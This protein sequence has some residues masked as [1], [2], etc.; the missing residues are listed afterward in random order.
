MD[1]SLSGSHDE[2]PFLAY[3]EC[4]LEEWTAER[5]ASNDYR[6]LYMDVAKGHIAEDVERLC[7]GRGYMYLLYYGGTTSI[8]QIKG[9][10]LHLF[11]EQLY[12]EH[13][14]E[15]FTKKQLHDPGNTSRSL[16]E[17]FADITQ[18]WRALDHMTAYEGHWMRGLSNKLDATEDGDTT[19][20]AQEGLGSLAHARGA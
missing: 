13:E 12:F 11:L 14:Q 8:C 18:T 7:W 1:W 19:G 3:L 16:A 20:E 6:L 9:I 2:E 15:A 5:A 4:W 17:A 10:G